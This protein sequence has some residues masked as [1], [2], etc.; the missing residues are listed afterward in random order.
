MELKLRGSAGKCE[1]KNRGV[2]IC[3][4]CLAAYLKIMPTNNR[5]HT[6]SKG[7]ARPIR[8]N[9]PTN[10]IADVSGPAFLENGDSAQALKRGGLRGFL[11]FTY[12]R[13]NVPTI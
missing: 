3:E 4:D 2:V 10:Y 11:R 6:K 5:T 1:A 13:F 7:R 9:T 12:Q 8:P